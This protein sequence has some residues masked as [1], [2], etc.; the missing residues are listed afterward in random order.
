[1]RRTKEHTIELLKN[2]KNEP[3]EIV[4]KLQVRKSNNASEIVSVVSDSCL[5][6]RQQCRFRNRIQIG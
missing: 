3:G 1:M 4:L 6:R 5:E 2:P